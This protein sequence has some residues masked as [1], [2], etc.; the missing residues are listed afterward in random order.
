MRI[1]AELLTQVEQRTNPLGDRELCLARLGIP[2]IE[3]LGR[4]EFDSLDLS[5]NRIT[6]LDNIPKRRRLKHLYLSGNL[7][8]RIDASNLL[9]NVT[10]L[11][12]LVLSHNRIQSLAELAPLRKCP[13]LDF[14][15]LLG[16]PVSRQQYYRL[17]VIHQFPHLTC[18]DFQKIKQKEREQASRLFRSAAGAALLADV[19]EEQSNRAT[20]GASGSS[21]KTFVP[22]ESVVPGTGNKPVLL[23]TDAEKARVRELLANAQ[24]AEEIAAIENAVRRGIVPTEAQ[25]DGQLSSLKRKSAEGDAPVVEKQEGEADPSRPKRQKV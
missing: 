20:T 17:Y 1:T 15:S 22:G 23:F 3:N 11:E 25:S 2:A 6:V 4:D 13:S 8:E 7:I 10:Q 9:K 14:L 5:D 19:Q 21:T 24:T 18:L 12:T 16:N